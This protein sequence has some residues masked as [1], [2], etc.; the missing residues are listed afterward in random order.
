MYIYHV[1]D[2]HHISRFHVRVTKK[3]VERIAN[4]AKLEFSDIEK[5]KFR[6]H[7][8]QILNYVEKLNELDTDDIEPTYY[9]QHSGET[10]RED[11]TTASMPR[12]EALKNAPAQA[13]GFVRVPKV[14]SQK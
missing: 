8:D 1:I 4:L 12:E 2:K 6:A 13:H 10:L 9:V 3:D 7:L 11:K 5:E 14:I